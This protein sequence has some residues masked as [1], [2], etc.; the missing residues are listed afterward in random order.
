M[1]TIKD[2]AQL[3][4]VSI[5]TVSNIIN[6]KNNVSTDVYQRVLK[7]MNELRYEPNLLARNLK[8]NNTKLVGVVLPNLEGHYNQILE[9]IMKVMDEKGYSLILKLTNN[10]KNTE[11]KI[12]DELVSFGV[13]G[14]LLVTCDETNTRKFDSIISRKVPIIFLE[15]YITAKDYNCVRFDNESIIYEQTKQQLNAAGH[16]IDSGENTCRD[17]IIITGLREFSAENDCIK[18]FIKAHE[19]KNLEYENKIISIHLSK[20]YIFKELI[21]YIAGTDKLPYCF[22]TTHKIISDSLLEVLG[23]FGHNTGI[24]TLA[25]ENW[26]VYNRGDH[27][28]DITRYAYALGSEGAN[29]LLKYFKSPVAFEN[30]QVTIKAHID[31]FENNPV[32]FNVE[33]REKIKLL[34]LDGPTIDALLK[35][36]PNFSRKFNMDI[37]HE[38]CSYTDLFNRIVQEHKEERGNID[39]FMIDLPW[40][41]NFVE[42]KYLLALDD[43]I[44]EDGDNFISNFNDSI[45]ETFIKRSEHIFTI[46]IMIGIQI[47]LF[48]KD[49]FEDPNIQRLYFKEFGIELHPPKTWTEFNLIARYFTRKYNSSSPV[50]YGTSIVGLNPTGIIEELLPRQWSYN[51]TG[52][53]RQGEVLINSM[54]NI[55]ALNNLK[56]TYQYSP[57]ESLNFWWDDQIKMFIKGNIAVINTF[58]SHTS[59]V[60]DKL[61]QS[62]INNVGFG[63]IPG[64]TP[65]LGGWVFGIN[66]HSKIAH[67]SYRF[68]KWA[69]S[70]ELSIHNTLL[71]GFVPKNNVLESNQLK[72]IYPW[73]ENI[74]EYIKSGRK[75]QT[76]RNNKG[77]IMDMY[78]FEK[79]LA[80]GIIDVILGKSDTEATLNSIK[81]KFEK[82]LGG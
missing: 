30:R 45:S 10:I 47:L 32:N 54:E 78:I 50:E 58:F 6:N 65:M 1:A 22:I 31:E 60:Y 51:G 9:G 29:L 26:Y 36:I 66:R 3:A 52:V 42:N 4:D 39:I 68:I 8:K 62:M 25:G 33:K 41:S 19:E 11:D 81:R 80:D 71:G 72:I 70:N 35:L 37:E 48:R 34:L 53:S 40:L 63:T 61:F 64:N 76:I 38:I 73:L 14:I 5:S 43:F 16:Y 7:V 27:L 21:E 69:C 17:I 13:K 56:E 20:E 46:P 12:L 2:V 55:K 75:R 79:V 24:Y 59:G 74:S 67:Q 15:R 49:L 23:L 44:N 18:G 57:P 28:K 77:K 82:L